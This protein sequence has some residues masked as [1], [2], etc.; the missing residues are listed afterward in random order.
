M[1]HLYAPWRSK[2]IREKITPSGCPLCLASP[3]EDGQKFVIKRFKHVYVMLNLYPYNAGHLMVIPFEHTGNLT[4]LTPETQAE[5]MHVAAICC[6]ILEK[7]LKTDGFN[8][9]LNMGG[10]ASGGT[11]PEHLHL[12]V[13]PRFYG[14]TNFLPLLSDTKQISHDLPQLYERLKQVF[15]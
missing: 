12:H 11:I 13:L 7:E 5:L 8:V 14:D 2:Y 10:K 15:N 1:E 6:T 9:G 3:E 4:D